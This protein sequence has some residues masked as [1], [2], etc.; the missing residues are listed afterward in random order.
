MGNECQEPHAQKGDWLLCAVL[1]AVTFQL[2]FLL[3]SV[4]KANFAFS[5]RKFIRYP[6]FTLLM[7]ITGP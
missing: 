6:G 5:S 4:S 7:K 3:H 1:M 2:G